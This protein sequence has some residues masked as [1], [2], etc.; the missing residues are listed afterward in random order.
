MIDRPY[1]IEWLNRWRDRSLVKVLTGM[2][3]CG[4]STILEIFQDELKD[5]GV[6][7]S[8]IF[9]I[10]FESLVEEYPLEA[11]ELYKYVIGRL[12]KT[13]TTYVFLDEVQRV[14][15][16]EVAVNALQERDDVDLYVTGSNAYFLSGDFATY[17]TGRQI[18]LKVHP[19]SFA[20]YYPAISEN[21]VNSG[22]VSYPVQYPLEY[23]APVSKENVFDR[24]LQYGGLPYA[25]KLSDER[26]VAAYL[27]G[28]FSTIL[29][30][31]ILRRRPRMN[32]KAFEDTA[33]F[34][35]DNVGN[36]S[37]V[38]KIADAL[39]TGGKSASQGAV[40]EY[41]DALRETF[42]L[43]KVNRYDIKGKEYLRTREKYYLGD[44]G[45]RFWLLGKTAGDAGHRIENLVYLELLRRFN[46]V[47]IGKQ[48]NKEVDFVTRDEWGLQY[49]QVAQTVMSKET[50]ERELK[51]LHAIDDNYP[52][53]LLT[54][55]TVGT[56]DAN[57][58]Q[59]MNLIDWLMLD[60]DRA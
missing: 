2:R 47:S 1:Y 53:V 30:K 20:E 18:E 58:V 15:E 33:S 60:P 50:F 8:N 22:G 45:Y 21:P 54:L 55:D 37:S 57:G 35:V 48:G 4:K 31:D 39:S 41:I 13:G 10:N 28:V 44:M 40:K 14:N 23:Q 24:Y 34:L 17:L 6:D 52:K 29:T 26:D 25:A 16:F 43:Y 51:P 12:G 56:G 9:S 11:R 7:D 27:E 42:L 49:F 32:V 46:R 19:L 59:H 5:S 3:R 38:K 36:I